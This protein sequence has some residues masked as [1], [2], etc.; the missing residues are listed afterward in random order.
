MPYEI[1]IQCVWQSEYNI[2]R[3]HQVIRS[4]QFKY[5]QVQ[6]IVLEGVLSHIVENSIVNCMYA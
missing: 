4:E 1:S 6:E 3:R 5:M 2:Q